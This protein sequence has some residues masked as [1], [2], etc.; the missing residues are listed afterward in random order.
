M[1]MPNN[2]LQRGPQAVTGWKRLAIAGSI[3]ALILLV[4]AWK[5]GARWEAA[6]EQLR[7]LNL[8]L[9]AGILAFSALWHM[10]LGA[11]KWWRIMVAQGAD[12]GFWEVFRVRLGSDPIRFAAP[13]KSG[14]LINAVYF[15]RYRGL[16]FGR[17][18]GAIVF[19]KALN[20]FGTVFWLYVGLAAMAS[21]PPAGL[22][23]L[24]TAMGM[25]VV[26]LICV[27]RLRRWAVHLAGK[28]HRKIGRLAADVLSAFEEFSLPRKLG[29]LLYGIVFQ[30]RPLVVCGLLFVAFQADRLPTLQELLG[31]GSVVV[32]MS[33]IPSLGGIGP[34]EAA[35]M[36]VFA[37]YTE[38]A[39]LLSIGLL[40]SF[41]VQGFPAL[42]GI[43]L[44]F[45]LIRE[46]T[47]RAAPDTGH[48]AEKVQ[49][50]ERPVATRGVRAALAPR[51]A[52]LSPG[53]ERAELG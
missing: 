1:T 43:P 41:A 33:N 31:L 46:L 53:A 25:G 13:L 11:D 44:M 12:V 10:L 24:H 7:R 22:L 19:D 35:L 8:P 28:V 5:A 37:G 29:F 9:C 47:G 6:A 49:E 36:A 18:A 30:L 48:P 45:P 42:L 39:T 21:L 32:L 40:M 52:T 2:V 20:F 51:S 16:G 38:P 3:S 4:L 26:M 15:S 23:G 17:A 14:E 34:R 50:G 27:R